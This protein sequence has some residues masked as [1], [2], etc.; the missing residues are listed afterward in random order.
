M[1]SYPTGQFADICQFMKRKENVI[2]LVEKLHTM[3]FFTK[4]ELKM[5]RDLENN[6]GF[7]DGQTHNYEDVQKVSNILFLINRDYGSSFLYQIVAMCGN[8]GIG[9]YP[10]YYYA[11]PDWAM[12]TDD[13]ENGLAGEEGNY[14]IKFR[15]EKYTDSKGKEKARLHFQLSGDWH[16]CY[17]EFPEDY[18][19]TKMEIRKWEKEDKRE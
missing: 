8:L 7:T 4:D 16:D 10:K 12:L 13:E 6:A 1:Y 9:E 19:P 15:T 3:R 18:I 17:K 5:A 11:I 14:V 2:E